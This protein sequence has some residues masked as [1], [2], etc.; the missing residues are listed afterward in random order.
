MQPTAVDS[1]RVQAGAGMGAT[2]KDLI[3]RME[4]E[5]LL[6]AEK[7]KG[8]GKEKVKEKEKSEAL[9]PTPP[10]IQSERSASLWFTQAHTSPTNNRNNSNNPNNPNSTSE[11][12]GSQANDSPFSTAGLTP[13]QLLERTL[14]FTEQLGW[15]DTKDDADILSLSLSCGNDNDS[16]SGSG[17]FNG[18][19]TDTGQGFR[20]LLSPSSRERDIRG[21]PRAGR[22]KRGGGGGSPPNHAN[23]NRSRSDS[24]NIS[25]NSNGSSAFYNPAY[26]SVFA[27][28]GN[29]GEGRGVRG[30]STSNSN[31]NSNSSTSARDVMK[32]EYLLALSS[33]ADSFSATRYV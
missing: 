19:A 32:S 16:G 1:A 3:E 2:M 30:A 13:E 6:G 14:D 27:H 9:H 26:A 4:E 23:R 31:S 17:V 7:D 11:K 15:L 8:K 21:S 33:H 10:Q 25:G 24:S 5:G 12:G 22:G 29:N 28:T 18:G 20:P